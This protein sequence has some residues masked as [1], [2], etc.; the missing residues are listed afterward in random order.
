MFA[1]RSVSR[2][3]WGK[4]MFGV[5]FGELFLVLLIVFFL[6]PKDL[7]K[8]MRHIGRFIG[9]TE[10]IRNELFTKKK[11]VEEMVSEA[12]GETTKLENT[13]KLAVNK[14]VSLDDSSIE[15]NAVEEK[16]QDV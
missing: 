10:R 14:V 16:V 4:N 13:L 11:D 1:S 9:T 8:V 2:C 6:S 15:N 5:G 12:E 7:P 3:G